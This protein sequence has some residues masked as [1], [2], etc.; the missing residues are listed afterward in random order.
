MLRGVGWFCFYAEGE[1]RRLDVSL[2]Q[3]PVSVGI[4]CQLLGVISAVSSPPPCASPVGVMA[5]HH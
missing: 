3:L 5:L 2:Y 1:A 4:T